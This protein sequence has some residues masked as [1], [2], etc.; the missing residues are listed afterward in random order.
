MDKLA[1]QL[2]HDAA[3]IEVRFSDDF[4]RRL[5]ASLEGAVQE[6]PATRQERPRPAIFWWASSLTGA[7]A[8]LLVVAVI[9]LRPAIDEPEPVA[10]TTSPVTVVTVPSID[11]TA[12]S[13]MLTRPLE[14]ELESLQSD[15]K[16][17]ERKVRE[18]IGL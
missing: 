9:N 1:E 11:L 8:A 6:V 13:A 15:L 14:K 10:A 12:E 18:D 5:T 2:K 3:Q 16:K 4:E 17:A 7:A